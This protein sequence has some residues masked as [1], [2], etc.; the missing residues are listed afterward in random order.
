MSLRP[1]LQWLTVN[2]ALIIQCL[3]WN[4]MCLHIQYGVFGYPL[5]HLRVLP[6]VRLPQVV[7][8]WSRLN[9]EDIF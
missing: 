3:S 5:T 8:H 4:N 6:G 9:I 2:L 7:D 1:G